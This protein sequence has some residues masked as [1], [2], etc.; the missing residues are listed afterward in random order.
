MPESFALQSACSL[1]DKWKVIFAPIGRMNSSTGECLYQT[2]RDGHY[3]LVIIELPGV[4]FGGSRR[5][6][7]RYAAISQLVRDSVISCVNFL[8]YGRKG[9][10][11]A[12]PALRNIAGGCY[13]TV[14]PTARHWCAYDYDVGKFE[15]TPSMR[16]FFCL[17]NLSLRDHACACPIGAPHG[18]AWGNRS[19]HNSAPGS[20]SLRYHH[21][22][23]FL[24]A[25]F[26]AGGY[27]HSAVGSA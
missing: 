16:V 14:K 4:Q 26:F 27:A 15:G 18:T 2:V 25:F 12:Q 17:S 20:S 11:W 23:D 19:V 8:C 3:G 24:S 9:N 1:M 10:I 5:D 22:L 6:R 13:P 21:E 7:M